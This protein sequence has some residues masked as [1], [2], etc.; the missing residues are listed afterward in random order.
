MFP[1]TG[2]TWTSPSLGLW[3][4]ILLS[5]ETAEWENGTLRLLTLAEPFNVDRYSGYRVFTPPRV[6]ST[7]T[8]SSTFSHSVRAVFWPGRKCGTWCRSVPPFSAKDEALQV[9]RATLAENG[10][11]DRHHVPHFLP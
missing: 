1:C 5:T 9:S 11:T 3:S 4:A 6:G 7:G 8:Q 10:G 2:R